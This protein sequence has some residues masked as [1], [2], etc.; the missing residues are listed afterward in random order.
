MNIDSF[1]LFQ[2][3]LSV[4]ANAQNERLF[5]E[6]SN[7]G[8]VAMQSIERLRSREYRSRGVTYLFQRPMDVLQRDLDL[9][10]RS[11]HVTVWDGA[12]LLGAMRLTA[13]PFE[14]AHETEMPWLNARYEN[15]MEFGRLVMA[16]VTDYRL[17][18]EKLMAAACLQSIKKGKTGIIAMCRRAQA[19][20]FERYGLRP[21]NNTPIVLPHRE[22]GAYWLMV[23]S[24]PSMFEP[25]SRVAQAVVR[26][27]DNLIE[28]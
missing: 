6:S 4:I 23:A 22:H 24:W 14:V 27:S 17:T 21:I 18:A 1:T 19:R 5:L 8:S 2:Q 28:S 3:D 9:D 10:K 11:N 15:H 26:R 12:K 7:H 13:A 20:L 25:I 16:S